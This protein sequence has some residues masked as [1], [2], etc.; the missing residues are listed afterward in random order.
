L[1]HPYVARVIVCDPRKIVRR[2]NKADKL[3]ARR[4]AELLR[5]GALRPVYHGEQST[6]AVKE[7]ALSYVSLVE[8]GTRIKNRLKALFRGRGIEFAY[9][10]QMPFFPKNHLLVD[11]DQWVQGTRSQ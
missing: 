8:D 11:A 3:D 5:T 6:R 7:L 2:G 4:L 10:V 1:I 9:L